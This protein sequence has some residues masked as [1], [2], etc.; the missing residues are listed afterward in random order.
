MTAAGSSV[1]R[2]PET[3]LICSSEFKLFWE[4]DARSNRL[5]VSLKDLTA[6]SVPYSCMLTVV[7]LNIPDRN[8]QSYLA[9]SC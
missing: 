3:E 4:R 8:E 7:K 5:I 1:F 9:K 2:M 6:T